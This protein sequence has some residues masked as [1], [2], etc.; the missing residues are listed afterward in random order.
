MLRV[1]ST[2]GVH[3]LGHPRGRKIGTRPGVKANWSK[4]FERAARTGVAIELDGDPRRQDIDY[5]LAADALAAGCFFAL[6]SD[7]HSPDELA[8]A[9]VAVAHARLAGIPISRIVNCWPLEH[10]LEWMRLRS[11]TTAP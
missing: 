6:D 7:A 2:V 4:V 5:V 11:T 9:D 1:V 10:V 3:I 8:F